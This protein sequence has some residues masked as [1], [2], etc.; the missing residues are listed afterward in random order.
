MERIEIITPLTPILFLF[1]CIS[2]SAYFYG[3]STSRISED[4]YV[5]FFAH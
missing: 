5:A 4:I 3:L 2:R 1:I